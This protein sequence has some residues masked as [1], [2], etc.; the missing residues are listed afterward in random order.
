MIDAGILDGD[1]V[2][3]RRQSTANNGDI[4]AA[5]VDDSA[6]IKRFFRENGHF[7]LQPENSTMQP[8]IFDEVQILGKVIGL[9][10]NM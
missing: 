1:M 3:I 5:L 10:R 4:V 2:V 9:I 6:T 7:R 8:M